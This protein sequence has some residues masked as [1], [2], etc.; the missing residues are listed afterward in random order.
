MITGTKA[1][2]NDHFD[3][4]VIGSGAA[5]LT[6]ATTMAQSGMRVLLAEKNE[7]LGGYSHGFS[8]DGFYWDHGGHIFL[9]YKLGAQARQVFQRLKLDQRLEMVPD[10]HDYRCTFPD[11]WLAI[12]ADMTEAADVFASRFPE[13][14]EGIATVLLIM[15]SMIDQVDQFVPSFSVADR[16]GERHLFDPVMEQFQRPKFGSIVSRSVRGQLMP[17]S[18]LLK[19]QTRTLTDLLD[20]HLRSPR[21]K[22][23]F[24][25]LSA[26]IGIG[27]S[28]LS[29]PIAGVFFI[30]ALRTMW[31]PKG[32][33]GQLA[34]SLAELFEE[35]GGT[36]VTGAD[37]SRI[38]L[39]EGRVTGVETADGRRYTS[40]FVVSACDAR[41][42]FLDML[43]PEAVPADLRE[44]LPKMD[45]SPSI[46][47]VHLGV[48]MD[49]E[50]YRA[51]IKR[52]N[53]IYPSDDID[54]SMMNFPEGNVEEAAFFL[55]V[56]TFHQPEMAPPGKHSLKLEAY[57]TIG[58]KG[59]DWERDKERISEVF[60]RRAEKLIPNLSQHIVTKELRTPN[61]LL[62]DT[63]N[64][65][66]AF[67]GWAFTPELLSRGRPQQR[68][69]VEGLYLA[70]HWTTP[71]AG[72]PW[73]M[74]SGFN[75]AGMVIADR[76]GGR[77]MPDPRALLK[78]PK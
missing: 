72:V 57:T 66:G 77:K 54:R 10:K 69:P 4:I 62:R 2:G 64:S 31:M 38:N 14:R 21:L 53:F 58:A 45:L 27:P 30:H 71:S 73:V 34:A 61:D 8:K 20:D 13:E 68:T 55:Y 26:G 17:G 39:H 74:V 76:K 33:F 41:R 19:Y 46:F 23:Y 6:C 67:A 63:G 28:R 65:E 48:D 40:G 47:Q 43:D 32:G 15:E 51:D 12:P 1:F 7:W 36:I 70:G 75:T 9:A 3:A 52:L 29:A 59:I 37:V 22:G 25:M 49:L 78:R 56:A 42:T 35:S 24:S 11:E 44:R 60:I 18:N 5:G 50:P 16:P